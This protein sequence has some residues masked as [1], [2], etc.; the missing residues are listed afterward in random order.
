MLCVLHTHSFKAPFQHTTHTH[1][2][3]LLFVVWVSRVEENTTSSQGPF[4]TLFSL[5][6]SIYGFHSSEKWPPSLQRLLNSLLCFISVKYFTIEN[7]L[8]LALP[9]M[10]LSTVLEIGTD[11]PFSRES[12]GPEGRRALSMVTQ[13]VAGLGLEGRCSHLQ[14]PVAEPCSPLASADI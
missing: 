2:H 1:T 13:A 12:G 8:L 14:L 3:T 5:C 4:L 9:Y 11:A 6:V 7:V 10:I